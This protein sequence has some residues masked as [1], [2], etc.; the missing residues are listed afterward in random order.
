MLDPKSSVEAMNEMLGLT[1]ASGA[2][3]LVCHIQLLGLSDPYMMLDVIDAGR[4]AGLKLTTEVYPYG[5]TATQQDALTGHAA[6][7]Y[8]DWKKQY[9]QECGGNLRPGVDPLSISL[10]SAQGFSMVAV[11]YLGEKCHAGTE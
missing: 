10:V 11:A 1:A 6:R 7:W 4:K 5:V 2:H 8:A 3:A 9:L